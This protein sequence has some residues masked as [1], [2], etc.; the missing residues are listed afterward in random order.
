MKLSLI[1]IALILF[2]ISFAQKES[3]VVIVDTNATLYYLP[4]FDSSNIIKIPLGQMVKVISNLNKQAYFSNNIGNWV[5]LDAGFYK[6]YKGWI[7]SFWIA[8]RKDFK[9]LTKFGSYILKG[10]IGDGILDY[11]F[12]K[13]G[14][15]VQ[16]VYDDK[17]K[18]ETTIKGNI[19]KKNMVICIEGKY[20]GKD[21]YDFFY[22][23]NND[24]LFTIY[25]DASGK[26]IMAE[27]G[28]LREN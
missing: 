1:I 25:P 27:K 18:F 16:K 15:F 23:D 8:G 20:L 5:Y 2:N 24:D 21:Y 22:L 28:V 6:S 4:D 3:F 7:P 9:K 12:N 26:P 14:T 11:K 10:M 17:G 13:D 19:Y